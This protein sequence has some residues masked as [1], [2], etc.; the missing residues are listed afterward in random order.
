MTT[1]RVLLLAAGNTARG[2]QAL[3]PLLLEHVRAMRVGERWWLSL[4]DDAQFR[5]E[6][7]LELQIND[8]ILFIDTVA[9]ATAP[10]ELR[11][12]H[13][14]DGHRMLP[15][16]NALSPED[17]LH[18]LSTIG[19]RKVLPA[20]FSLDIRGEHFELGAGLSA[21]AREHLEAAIRLMESLL[22]DTREEFWRGHLTTPR[23][24]GG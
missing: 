24:A 20:C 18:T 1:R 12:V 17:V 23:A 10:F 14:R 13:A 2:D 3:A 7:S 11:E 9:D 16:N 21:K 8:L 5:V 15:M 4:I 22:A 19:R 6:H